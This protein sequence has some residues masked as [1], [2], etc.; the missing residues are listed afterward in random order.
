MLNSVA[1]KAEKRVGDVTKLRT[2]AEIIMNS[3]GQHL[4]NNAMRH[5]IEV[6]MDLVNFYECSSDFIQVSVEKMRK[7]HGPS[8][9]F[10]TVKALLSLRTGMTKQETKEVLESCK[11]VLDSFANDNTKVL[12]GIFNSIDS[13][14]AANQFTSEMEGIAIDDELGDDGEDLD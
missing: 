1:K 10:N 3:F 8:F 9:N 12:D 13:H 6:L 2:D 14:T 5:S 4:S 11:Q 7:L